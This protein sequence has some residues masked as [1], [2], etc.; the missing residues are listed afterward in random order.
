MLFYVYLL[1]NKFI[2]YQGHE[3]DLAISIKAAEMGATVIERHFTLNKL[4]KVCFAILN[5]R[6][7]TLIFFF[8]EKS[9]YVYIV[10]GYATNDKINRFCFKGTDHSCSLNPE[11]LALLVKYAKKR[12]SIMSLRYL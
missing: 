2:Y 7:E 1:L 5:L 8:K 12:A 4:Q 11:E 6:F 10:I 3:E 9:L